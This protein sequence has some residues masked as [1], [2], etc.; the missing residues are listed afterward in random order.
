MQNPVEQSAGFFFFYGH[1]TEVRP[2]VLVV[3]LQISIEILV[4]AN[5]Q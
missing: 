1:R 5:D 4:R 2:V 3:V